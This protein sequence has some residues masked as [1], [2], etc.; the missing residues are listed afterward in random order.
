MTSPPPGCESNR[1]AY[2]RLSG[3]GHVNICSSGICNSTQTGTTQMPIKQHIHPTKYC[4]VMWLDGLHIH[5]IYKGTYLYGRISLTW[6]MKDSRDKSR[7]WMIPFLW[8]TEIGKTDGDRGQK[9]PGDGLCLDGGDG[10][11]FG[12]NPLS[13]H[14]R[15]GHL[16]VLHTKVGFFFPFSF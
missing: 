10:H 6:W 5:N 9:S 14:L 1:N 12:Q 11:L 3:D 15:S 7:C 13:S 2:I 8:R 4:S 16:M